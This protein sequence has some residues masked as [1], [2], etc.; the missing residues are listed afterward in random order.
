M[1]RIRNRQNVRG[2]IT[3]CECGT[4]LGNSVTCPVVDRSQLD[5]NGHQQIH[6]GYLQDAK[7]MRTGKPHTNA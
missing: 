4:H 7:R 1:Y 6:T 5:S 3:E 2:P